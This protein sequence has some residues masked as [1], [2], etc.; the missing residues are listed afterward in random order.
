MIIKILYIHL[1]QYINVIKSGVFNE[2][3]AALNSSVN[4]LIY[5]DFIK[6]IVK[7]KLLQTKI[8]KKLN[9]SKLPL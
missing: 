4:A 2:T 8:K 3:Q 1:I 7:N 5:I 9:V 6:F